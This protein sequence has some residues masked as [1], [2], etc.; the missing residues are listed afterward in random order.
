VKRAPAAPQRLAPSPNLQGHLHLFEP[1]EDLSE[2]L[3]LN[4]PQGAA[5]ETLLAELRCVDRFLD[6]DIDAP[7]RILFDGPSGTG[8]TLTARWLGWKLKARVLV[9]DI[10]AT[11]GSHLGETSGEIGRASCRERV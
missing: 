5:V 8:K 2:D 7:T 9:L 4:G 11:V 10:S 1:D 3:I 6:A